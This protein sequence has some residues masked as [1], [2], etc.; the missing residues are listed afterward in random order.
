MKMKHNSLKRSLF[1]QI[2]AEIL[3][4]ARRPDPTDHKL[5]HVR[6]T[7]VPSVDVKSY[8]AERYVRNFAISYTN[9]S[10]EGYSILT[11]IPIDIAVGV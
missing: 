8:I 4:H 7:P 3:A 11:M 10:E 5:I 2:D 9:Y 1:K 6:L